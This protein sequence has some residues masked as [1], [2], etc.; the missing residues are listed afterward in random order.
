MEGHALLFSTK[1]VSA[2]LVPDE[3]LRSA[4]EGTLD[5]LDAETLSG[6]GFLVED[7]AGEREEVLSV[8][9]DA[10]EKRIFNAIAVLNL[11]CNLACQ[12]C[13]EGTMKGRHYMT[14]ETAN[15]LIEYVEGHLAKGKDAHID[16]YGGE[17]LLSFDLITSISTR[18]K[19]AAKDMDRKFT[20]GMVTNG[21]LLTREKV[22]T[23]LTLGFTG[24]KITL[25]GPREV[26]DSSRPFRSGSGSF[27]VIMRNLKEVCGIT[28][29]QVGGNYTQE[30][31]PLFP[32][33]LDYLSDL[34][35]TPDRLDTVKFD[36]VTRT[37]K[38]FALPDFRDGVLSADEPWI[39]EASL[40]LREEILKRGYETPRIMPI[41][42]AMNFQDDVTIGVDGTLYKCP[43]FIGCKGHEVGHVRSGLDSGFR[44]ALDLDAWKNDECLDCPYLP[45][46][47]GGCKFIKALRDGSMQGVECRKVYYDATLETLVLQDLKYL[48]KAPLP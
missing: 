9:S 18:L 4:Q 27:D 25:D 23:M 7:L 47:F 26:H 16:F 22:E 2:A 21:T 8:I 1:R 48:L 19:A 5:P 28:T 15:L 14:K 10:D 45:L 34:G 41:P 36:P 38:E 24:A 46:C 32:G 43:A 3:I 37:N 13:F 6:L 12:Y 20:F 44:E 31:H 40:F 17:P 35:I 39:I 42:C 30:N 29:I 33:L 11:D